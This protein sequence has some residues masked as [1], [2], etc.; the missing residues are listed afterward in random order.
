MP[1][2]VNATLT[3]VAS[4]LL[5]TA[6]SRVSTAVYVPA[7]VPTCAPDQPS[8]IVGAFGPSKVFVTLPLGGMR[9]APCSAEFIHIKP[10]KIP[11][12]FPTDVNTFIL[13]VNYVE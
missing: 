13:L 9:I 10:R 1:F 7:A 4:V 3:V 8:A 2:A 11:R 5:V 6:V 12:H